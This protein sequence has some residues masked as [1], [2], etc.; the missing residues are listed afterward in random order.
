VWGTLQ[1]LGVLGAAVMMQAIGVAGTRTKR[2]N[3]GGSKR[4]DVNRWIL[5]D[6]STTFTTRELLLAC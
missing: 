2:Q 4:I 5:S 3:F 6:D 1:L